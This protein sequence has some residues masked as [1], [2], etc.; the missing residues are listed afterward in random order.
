[1]TYQ[2]GKTYLD[3]F[4]NPCL[5][6]TTE[7]ELRE[8]SIVGLCDNLHSGDQHLQVWFANGVALGSSDFNGHR[9]NLAGYDPSAPKWRRA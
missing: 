5:I 1:M 4:G 7:A 9:Y 2:T 6:L 8:G 3:G